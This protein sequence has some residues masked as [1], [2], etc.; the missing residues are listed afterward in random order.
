MREQTYYVVRYRTNVGHELTRV[1][2][3]SLFGG[4]FWYDE[5]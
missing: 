5:E 3:L 1:C 4:V 2:K